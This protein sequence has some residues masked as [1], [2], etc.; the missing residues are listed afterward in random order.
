MKVSG[1]SQYAK[2]QEAIFDYP[3]CCLQSKKTV[4]T[5]NSDSPSDSLNSDITIAQIHLFNLLYVKLFLI[6]KKDSLSK[7]EKYAAATS[8]NFSGMQCDNQDAI[9]CFL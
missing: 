2:S 9:D 6:I 7:H 8:P 4:Q 3:D 1:G 5:V